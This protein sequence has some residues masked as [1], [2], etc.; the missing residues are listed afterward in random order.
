M[1]LS[2]KKILEE[3]KKGSI[4][5]KPFNIKNMGGNSYDVHLSKYLA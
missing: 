1:I 4:V 2:D 5:I 3:I